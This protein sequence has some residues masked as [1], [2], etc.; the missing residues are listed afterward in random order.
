MPNNTLPFGDKPEIL[1]GKPEEWWRASAKNRRQAKLLRKLEVDKLE[2]DTA[3]FGG[4]PATSNDVLVFN[5]F[6]WIPTDLSA[7]ISLD[8]LT[9]TIIA[10][11]ST[12]QFLRYNGSEWTNQTV[13]IVSTLNDLSDVVISAP[14]DDQVLTYDSGTSMWVNQTPTSGDV[15]VTKT[16]NYTLTSTD[17]TVLA[18]ATGGAFTLTLPTAIGH[19][20][21]YTVKKIDTTASAVA[22]VTAVLGQTIDLGSMVTLSQAEMA[23]SFRSDGANY[24]IV[25]S[26]LPGAVGPYGFKSMLAFWMGGASST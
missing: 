13:V 2:S 14:V 5:G 18:D 17:V 11:P 12:N 4:L 10:V 6:N 25:D 24:W 20:R 15:V 19:K 8:D 7:L 3:T 23:L 16:A 22:V 21:K 1:P 26:F 9:D